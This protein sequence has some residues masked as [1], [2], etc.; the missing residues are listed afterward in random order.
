MVRQIIFYKKFFVDFY[1]NQEGKV[2]EKIEY[3]LDLVRFERQVPVKFFKA[4]ENT[5]GLY[6]VRVITAF[7]SIRILCFMDERNLVVLVNCFVKKTQKTPRK[8]IKLAEKLKKEYLQ[9]KNG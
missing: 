2:Q 5:D 4:L 7:K 1:R 6:E 9:E 3:V 8:E